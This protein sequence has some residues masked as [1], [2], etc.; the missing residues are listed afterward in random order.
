MKKR[1][2]GDTRVAEKD[3]I[4]GEGGVYNGWNSQL[5]QWEAIIPTVQRAPGNFEYI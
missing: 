5:V 2:R 3:Q 4:R 1:D